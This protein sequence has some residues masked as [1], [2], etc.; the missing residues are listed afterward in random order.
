MENEFVEIKPQNMY[1]G[2]YVTQII[3]IAAIIITVLIIKFFFPNNFA[4]IKSWCEN[5]VFEQT[6]IATDIT[7]EASS[8]V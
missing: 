7:E 6:N 5:N 3:C 4:A 8:E 2:I 1:F